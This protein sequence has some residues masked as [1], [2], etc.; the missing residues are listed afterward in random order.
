MAAPDGWWDSIYADDDAIEQVVLD[1]LRSH[2]DLAMSQEAPVKRL[3]CPAGHQLLYV[4]MGA[5]YNWRPYLQA[6]NKR[7]EQMPSLDGVATISAATPS[8]SPVG[9][10][11]PARVALRCTKCRFRATVR[12]PYLFRRYV[13]ALELESFEIPLSP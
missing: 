2:L 5:D 3:T 4:S 9:G 1:R 11:L 7:G 12:T 6:T 8:R 13:V 10:A